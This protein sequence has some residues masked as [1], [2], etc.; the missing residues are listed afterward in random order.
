MAKI[1]VICTACSG[2]GNIPADEAKKNAYGEIRTFPIRCEKCEGG[3]SMWAEVEIDENI[4]PSGFLYFTSAQ[5]LD[6]TSNLPTDIDFDE[7]LARI[8]CFAFSVPKNES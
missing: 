4:P 2:R 5:T 6:C 7:W 8:A 3:G 1:K